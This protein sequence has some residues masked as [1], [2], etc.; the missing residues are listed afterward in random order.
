MDWLLLTLP[1]ACMPYL[2]PATVNTVV[3]CM[4]NDTIWCSLAYSLLISLSSP[5]LH[6]HLDHHSCVRVW[7]YLWY[8]RFNIAVWHAGNS[9]IVY[10]DCYDDWMTD[11]QWNTH[12]LKRNHHATLAPFP[13]TLAPPVSTSRHNT[14]VGD[15]LHCTLF[16][17]QKSRQWPNT[18]TT[19]ERLH[20]DGGTLTAWQMIACRRRSWLILRVR[21]R[22]D[23]PSTAFQRQY[24][25]RASQ[26]VYTVQTS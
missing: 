15:T 8:R 2:V 16:S 21:W 4:S 12:L 9:P 22:Y 20:R 25:L 5:T 19:R 6:Y 23:C 24:H 26:T 10:K 7:S 1:M 13:R 11:R 14:I 18:L 3:L 17:I